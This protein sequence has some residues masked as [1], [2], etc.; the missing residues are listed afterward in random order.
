MES[1]GEIMGNNGKWC[2]FGEEVV[3][4]M[5]DK[6]CESQFVNHKTLPN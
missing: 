6:I 5:I 3:K 2:E 4:A 1:W